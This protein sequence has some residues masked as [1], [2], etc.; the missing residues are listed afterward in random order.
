M[1]RWQHS[2]KTGFQNQT[3]PRSDGMHKSGR[4]EREPPP[5][6]PE[7]RR[8]QAT[9]HV[10]SSPVVLW[11]QAMPQGPVTNLG[12]IQP[13]WILAASGH[14][15]TRKPT[16]AGTS[17]PSAGSG[18]RGQLR[19]DSGSSHQRSVSRRPVGWTTMGRD[20]GKILGVGLGI[21][22]DNCGCAEP[23]TATAPTGAGKKLV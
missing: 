13:P 14:M 22:V 12:F 6:A 1:N 9:G 23:S 5:S 17:H 18:T 8:L 20:Q 7:H 11:R 4:P 15:L 16:R 19:L 3:D 2:N 21:G 10:E